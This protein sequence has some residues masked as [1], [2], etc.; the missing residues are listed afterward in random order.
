MR[1]KTWFGIET[2]DGDCD[3]SLAVCCRDCGT[4]PRFGVS[5]ADWEG[6][7]GIKIF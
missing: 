4:E 2:L 6:G 7:Q 5:R 3:F 1:L